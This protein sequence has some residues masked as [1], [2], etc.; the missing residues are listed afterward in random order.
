[1]AKELKVPGEYQSRTPIS[2]QNIF[3]KQKQ[4]DKVYTERDYKNYMKVINTKI[5]ATESGM[6]SLEKNKKVSKLSYVQ[7]VEW[8]NGVSLDDIK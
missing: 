2:Q 3:P 1:M 5:M 4:T 7:W 8:Q 6:E